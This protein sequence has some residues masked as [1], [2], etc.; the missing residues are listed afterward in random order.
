MKRVK[1]VVV[2]TDGDRRAGFRSCPAGERCTEITAAPD[3]ETP[4]QNI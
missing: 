2:E 3:Q 4:D 1:S